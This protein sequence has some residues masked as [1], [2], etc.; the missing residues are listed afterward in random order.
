[1]IRTVVASPSILAPGEGRCHRR[2][3]RT[4][5]PTT[6]RSLRGAEV[7]RFLPRRAGRRSETDDG[8]RARQPPA[9]RA[10]RR[11]LPPNR[12]SWRPS[13][14]VYR[15]GIA[16]GTRIAAAVQCASADPRAE[17]GLGG[18]GRIVQPGL[19]DV[20]QTL[21]GWSSRRISISGRRMNTPWPPG[22]AG[23]GDHARGSGAVQ[24][25]SR[26]SRA[27]SRSSAVWP[28]K[29]TEAPI[30]RAASAKRR[31]R[32]DR[33]AAARPLTGFAS[34]HERAR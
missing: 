27:S 34:L 13:R 20:A 33:A 28:I 31:W 6:A 21:A 3:P 4:G 10:A 22:Q 16:R 24:P 30:S 2:T 7:R 11:R 32:A 8:L 12:R 29:N 14:G 9:P 26:I 23:D 15:R 19:A 18:V 1:M 25:S 17:R 5:A